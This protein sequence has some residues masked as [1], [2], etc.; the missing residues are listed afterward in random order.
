VAFAKLTV[1]ATPIA[2]TVLTLV[3]PAKYAARAGQQVGDL[4]QHAIPQPRFNGSVV[5]QI[6]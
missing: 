4:N 5:N 1:E 2:N 3:G 6:D